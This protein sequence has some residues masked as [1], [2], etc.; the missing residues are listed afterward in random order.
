MLLWGAVFSAALFVMVRGADEFLA[1]A[2]KIGLA[3]G[4][5]PFVIGVLLVGLGTSLPELVSAVFGV[6]KGVPEIVVANAVGS[7]ISNILLII[8][9]VAILNGILSVKKDIVDIDLPLLAG[10]TVI[11]IAVAWDRTITAAEAFLLVVSYLV[12]LG[13]TFRHTPKQREISPSR[14]PPAD[15]VSADWIYLV[16]GA[17]GLLL[18]AKYVVDAVVELSALFGIAP[19]LISITAIAL[20]TSLPELIVSV[21]AVK[22]GKVDMA[23]GNIFGSNAFNVLVVV[24]LPGMFSALPVDGQTFSVGIPIMVAA[25][26]LFVITGIS[27]KI[28]LWEGAMYLILYIFFIGKLFNLL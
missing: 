15:I 10:G 9:I 7:N 24:G 27:R 17:A 13:Y 2:E 1:R 4:L 28:H 6:I 12:H 20:G 26:I 19:A 14:K 5:S 3:K 23:V 8:G 21:K 11:F 18:G 25:T 16:L 22:A